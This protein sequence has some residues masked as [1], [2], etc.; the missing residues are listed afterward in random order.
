[1]S[2]RPPSSP[3]SALAREALGA[4][5]SEIVAEQASALARAGR[6]LEKALAELAGFDAGTPPQRNGPNAPRER[7]A[8]LAEARQALW[9]LVVQRD[10]CGFRNSAEVL[11]AYAV[12]AEVSRGVTHAPIH[13]RRRR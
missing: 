3:S 6:R 10:A 11:S 4:L 7:P 8:L 13:W 9:Y 5:E 1:M 12:P 2:L